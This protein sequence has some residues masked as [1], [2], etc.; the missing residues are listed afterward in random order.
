MP[1]FG[2]ALAVLWLGEPFRLFQAAGIALIV[3]GVTLVQL[4]R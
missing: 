1:A 3:A 2:T 4:A